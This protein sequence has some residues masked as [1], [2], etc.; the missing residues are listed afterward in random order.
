MCARTVL[1]IQWAQLDDEG[2]VKKDF[3]STVQTVHETLKPLGYEKFQ[4]ILNLMESQWTDPVLTQIMASDEDDIE[5]G[6][7]FLILYA[8]IYHSYTL[9][10]GTNSY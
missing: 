10:T 5:E 9:L 1:N 7:A 6:K 4:L 3:V 8:E 2:K